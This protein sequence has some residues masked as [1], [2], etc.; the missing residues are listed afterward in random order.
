[1]SSLPVLNIPM[2]C[3]CL[4]IGISGGI[5]SIVLLH[6]A[7]KNRSQLGNNGIELRAVHVNHQ[8]SSNSQKWQ[9]HVEMVC[10]KWDVSL[11]VQSVT[12]DI[13]GQGLE[14]AARTARYKV[15][16]QLL[17]EGDVLALAHHQE[18]QAETFL[19]RLLRGAGIHGLGAIP[20]NRP[21]GSA[22]LWRPLLTIPKQLIIDYA[23]CNKLAWVEDESNRDIQY[24][25][26][27]LRQKLLPLL[28]ERWPQASK[29]IAQASEHARE[30]QALLDEY[31]AHDLKNLNF[32]KW[33]S[34]ERR[35]SR[36]IVLEQLE[37]FP[38]HCFLCLK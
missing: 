15:F 35:T 27:F 25:R 1:M 30:A 17:G 8:I 11:S 29:K 21:L 34:I 12:V 18:D 14:Q 24:D 22:N 2:P 23:K 3:K 38:P 5:D 33:I 36:L 13:I 9:Q 31:A 32:I 10:A 6:W 37:V 16:D 7:I 28:R 4:W 26:N 19:L 20:D